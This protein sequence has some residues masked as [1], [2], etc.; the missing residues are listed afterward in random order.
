MGLARRVLGSA[1]RKGMGSWNMQGRAVGFVE[2]QGA[3]GRGVV[4]SGVPG[5]WGVHSSG[6]LAKHS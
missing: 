6:M 5:Q 3:G 1:S 4:G 2:R